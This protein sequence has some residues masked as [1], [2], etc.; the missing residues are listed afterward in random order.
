[1]TKEK[2]VAEAEGD[3]DYLFERVVML[4]MQLED[5]EKRW[6]EAEF[7]LWMLECG[8]GDGSD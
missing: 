2:L 8:A 4:R 7:R 3:S 6:V 1:M 5:T